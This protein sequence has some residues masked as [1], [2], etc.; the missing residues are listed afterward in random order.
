MGDNGQHLVPYTMAMNIVDLF[1][2]VKIEEKYPVRCAG[3]GR[4]GDGCFERLFILTA[5]RQAR[6]AV[7]VG[8]FAHVLLGRNA[9][10]H[11]APLPKILSNS[12]NEQRE[13]NQSADQESLVELNYR[14]MDRDRPF[15]GENVH[16]IGIVRPVPTLIRR[17]RVT[18]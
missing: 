9:G 5:I 6:E 18:I 3:A 17:S 8:K 12:K 16:F 10:R 4:R 13:G 2:T 7:L 14:F 1:E 15:V 11:F